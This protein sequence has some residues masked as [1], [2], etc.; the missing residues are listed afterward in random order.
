MKKSEQGGSPAEPLRR[1]FFKRGGA[2]AG[3]VVT[4]TTLSALSAYM[5][6]AHDGR[7]DHDEHDR[8]RRRGRRS[9]YGELQRTPDQNGQVILALPKD[10]Q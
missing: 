1:S 2:L 10:L 3:S 7:R 9:D 5:A 4:G 8:D 6:F